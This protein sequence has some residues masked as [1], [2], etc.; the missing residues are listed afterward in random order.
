MLHTMTKLLPAQEKTREIGYATMTGAS[1]NS[2]NPD[3]CG[4]SPKGGLEPG[5]DAGSVNALLNRTH[6]LTVRGTDGGM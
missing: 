3:L 5:P 4:H 6:V 2:S 1:D